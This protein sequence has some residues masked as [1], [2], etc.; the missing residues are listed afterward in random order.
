MS[1]IFQKVFLPKKKLMELEQKQEIMKIV[2]TATVMHTA[3]INKHNIVV[4]RFSIKDNGYNIYS[5]RTFDGSR[6]PGQEIQ[7][8][9]HIHNGKR[10]EYATH[11]T[12]DK[13]A[14]R[15]YNRMYA[16]WN[17]SKGNAR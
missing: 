7:Y 5:E 13:F 15:V 4:R 2:S 11:S 17:K 8:T 1:T 6:A 10:I 14:H 3:Y 12:I 9:L 16:S